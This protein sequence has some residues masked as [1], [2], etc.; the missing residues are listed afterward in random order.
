MYIYQVDACEIG[1]QQERTWMSLFFCT[2]MI[3][4]MWSY[5]PAVIMLCLS[6]EKSQGDVQ[7]I[8][9]GK[10]FLARTANL[11]T[12]W[13]KR[14]GKL[15]SIENR[16]IVQS[17]F[18]IGSGCWHRTRKISDSISAT[19]SASSSSSSSETQ[20]QACSSWKSRGGDVFSTWTDPSWRRCQLVTAEGEKK[21][22]ASFIV[23]AALSSCLWAVWLAVLQ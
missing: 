18:W 23:K 22:P 15:D 21:N 1:S 9:S 4:N 13:R 5:E 8:G 14:R 2:L 17:S 10:G 11:P 7:M 3:W 12:R 16:D 20:S 6:W 19:V